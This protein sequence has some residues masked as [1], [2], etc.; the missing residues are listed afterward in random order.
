L[1]KALEAGKLIVGTIA[2][3]TDPTGTAAIALG[4]DAALQTKAWFTKTP[5]LA[6]LAKEL[7]K[8]FAA[9]LAEPQFD[10][11]KDARALLPQMLEHASTSSVEIAQYGLDPNLVLANM[12]ARLDTAPAE[13]RTPAI[14]SAFEALTR[15]LITEACNDTRLEQALRPHLTRASMRNQRKVLEGQ[16]EDRETRDAQYSDLKGLM[17]QVLEG[18]TK[19]LSLED[20]KKLAA[21]FGNHDITDKAGLTEFLTQKAEEYRS[22]RATIDALDD[23]VAAIAN[24]K[25]AAQDAAAK[26][27]FD[28]VEAL[29]A[30]VDEV[31]TEIAAETKVARAKNALLRNDPDTAFRLLSAAADS[32]RSIDLLDPAR[33]RQGHIVLLYQHGLRYPG[34]RW[35]SPP[36]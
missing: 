29:L 24:L 30:R 1:A 19:A 26:L 2:V 35:T 21:R 25:G 7:D 36:G 4:C 13:Y 15:P 20:M 5:D 6:A 32:F 34:P 18:Q 10:K 31:E 22:Y 16:A 27:D 9:R 12:N 28:E 11:P 14:L 17:E 3:C 33:K 23:R 8:K